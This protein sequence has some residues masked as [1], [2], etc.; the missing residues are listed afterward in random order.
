VAVLTATTRLANKLA[1]D[2]AGR[3]DALSIS[4]LRLTNVC[5]NAELAAHT[6]NNDIEVQLAHTG[7][8]RLTGFFVGFDAE[9]GSS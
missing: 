1:F 2:L 7:D 9:R 4:H 5:L 6:I 3:R 8:N